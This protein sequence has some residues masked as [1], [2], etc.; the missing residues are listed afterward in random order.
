MRKSLLII[1]TPESCDDWNCPIAVKRFCPIIVADTTPY[2]MKCERHTKCP[3][4]DLTDDQY[5][6]VV[7]ILEGD[8]NG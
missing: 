5:V 8:K 7:S 3:L 6:K 4:V 1:D 2:T